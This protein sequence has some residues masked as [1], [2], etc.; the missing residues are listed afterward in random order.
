M[1]VVRTGGSAQIP[2]RSCGVG[3]HGEA[4]VHVV[5]AGLGK[6][7]ERLDR[8]GSLF[9]VLIGL[10]G[11]SGSSGGNGVDV[12]IPCMARLTRNCL[13]DP[14]Q[15]CA[16]PA[17]SCPLLVHPLLGVDHGGLEREAEKGIP[18]CSTMCGLY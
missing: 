8:Q 5:H 10:I 16:D 15:F 3:V 1:R 18:F 11:W 7:A 6:E 12:V 9:S 4:H 14:A 13:T 2:D 17:Q